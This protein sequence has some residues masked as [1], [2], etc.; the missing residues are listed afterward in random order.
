MNK[1]DTISLANMIL[2]KPDTSKSSWSDSA[3]KDIFAVSSSNNTANK[4]NEKPT[5]DIYAD[6]YKKETN[7]QPIKQ[8][9]ETKNEPIKKADNNQQRKN[10]EE[11]SNKTIEDKPNTI[12]QTDSKNVQQVK[13]D[14]KDIVENGEV[15]NEVILVEAEVD[16]QITSL[17][18]TMLNIDLKPEQVLKIN[19]LVNALPLELKQEILENPKITLAFLKENMDALAEQLNLSGAQ[20][21]EVD[22][23][24]KL[25]FTILSNESDTENIALVDIQKLLA[26]NPKISKNFEMKTELNNNSGN[27]NDLNMQINALK[28]NQN[29]PSQ[30]NLSTANG[31]T[32]NQSKA[33]EFVQTD[34]VE[35]FD[36]T[37]GKIF[38]SSILLNSVKQVEVKSNQFMQMINKIA[39]EIRLTVDKNKNE[40]TIKLQ[41]ETLGKLT[42]KISSENGVMNASFFAENDKAKALIERNMMELKASLENQGIQVQNLT[43][44]VDQNQD[45]LT[46]HRAIMEAQKYNKA[47]VNILNADEL[48]ENILDNPYILD[49]IFTELI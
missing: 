4:S 27:T 33:L 15:E 37:G 49:D 20:S 8:T 14:S 38:S 35:G 40:M 39:N 43:V 3:F 23:N 12:S 6:K 9:K 17:I 10:Q 19:E 48:S 41:P 26:Q 1:V 34:K 11:V 31:F 32:E 45:E 29:L 22:E 36:L 13:P 28:V 5:K 30:S 7:S 2:P 24:F 44:T 42:V 16:K 46:R 18:Q 21:K 25:I 47:Q